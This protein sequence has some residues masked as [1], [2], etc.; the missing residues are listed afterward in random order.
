M[1]IHN[2]ITSNLEVGQSVG[3]VLTFCREG[4]HVILYRSFC[5]LYALVFNYI[6]VSIFDKSGFMLTLNFF[7]IHRATYT[8]ILNRVSLVIEHKLHYFF[9]FIHIDLYRGFFVP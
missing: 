1:V 3:G 5:R 9:Q 6:M 4:E 7:I 8:A 2:D